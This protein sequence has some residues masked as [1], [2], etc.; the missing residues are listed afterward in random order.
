[1]S[2]EEKELT[3]TLNAKTSI[4]ILT[5]YFTASLP[6]KDLFLANIP[7]EKQIFNHNTPSS[8]VKNGVLVFELMA[9]SIKDYLLDFLQKGVRVRWRE[10]RKKNPLG[11]PGQPSLTL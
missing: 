2:S 6:I 4:M 7:Y 8:Y 3:G 5:R 9:P 10:R 11:A 1:M